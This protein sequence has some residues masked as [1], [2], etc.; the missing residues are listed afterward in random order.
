VDGDSGN[1]NNKDW[2][3]G[4]RASA[5][6]NDNKSIILSPRFSTCGCSLHLVNN[7]N[8]QMDQRFSNFI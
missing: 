4:W 2:G 7:A 8:C 5:S 1:R 6:W 3:W